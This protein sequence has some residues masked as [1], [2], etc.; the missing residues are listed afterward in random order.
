M[1]SH[2]NAE[3]LLG[4]LNAAR[5]NR[6]FYGKRMDVQHFQME[7]DYGKLKQW[8]LN[9]LT[10][11]MGVLCGLQV[12]VE[13][14]RL[15]VEPGVAIDA[16]GREIVVPARASIAPVLQD[17]GCCGDAAAGETPDGIYT[18]WLCYHECLTDRQAVMASTCGT[19][20]E[21]APSTIVET[22]CLKFEAGAPP[23]QTDPDWC[24]DLWP[25]R[26]EQGE[27]RPPVRGEIGAGGGQG[28]AGGV[29]PRDPE[30][31]DDDV[32][33]MLEARRSRRHILCRLFEETCAPQSG[34]PCVPLA[35]VMLRGGRIL[36]DSCIV[37]PHIYSN[38][39]LLDLILCLAEKIEDCCGKKP[40]KTLLQVRSVDFLNRTPGAA[41]V[42]VGSMAS[43]LEI[44]EVDING[45]PNAIRIRFSKPLAT[46]Q[47]APTT[48]ANGDP[49]YQ[50][51]NVQ[52]LAAD[53]L[54][55]LPFVPGQLTLEAPDTIRFDLDP[56]SPY[57]RSGGGW[58]K[59]RYRLFL[60]GDESLPNQRQALADTDGVALDG[61]AKAPAGGV[62]S[63]NDSAGGD[64]SAEFVIGGKRPSALLHVA[65]VEFYDYDD[66]GAER[67]LGAIKSPLKRTPLK[68]GFR[69]LRIKFDQ[70][71]AAEGPH[72]PSTPAPEEADY[73]RHNVQLLV[74]GDGA[75]QLAM[76][77]LPGELTVEA[78]D[79]LRF[80]VIG[81]NRLVDDNGRWYP[82]QVSL[83]LFLRGTPVPDKQWYELTHADGASL[84]GEPRTPSGGVMSGDDNAG[85]DF[86]AEILVANAA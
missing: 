16:L 75:S 46:D 37:R 53:Q 72:A 64:F 67:K 57:R 60:R 15:Y 34:N 31:L 10:L 1:H 42:L 80:Q 32:A 65:S 62:I 24:A 23:L 40:A 18:L 6:Y 66:A 52:I 21:C 51:H 43:P 26:P 81:G 70:P 22:Y 5:R 39:Q 79:T 3:A 2:D 76:E 4:V 11:G 54:D 35:L 45:Q 27:V 14:G 48:H 28:S 41:E 78:P 71:F 38:R 58:Q 49:D 13:E 50:L 74:T 61:E 30:D 17:G 68:G 84:D 69:Y 86:S 29:K 59:G 36:S 55:G 83:R 9:R 12:S 73:Q 25:K 20:D 77:Y 63:G 82:Q 19:R 85:G 8:M 56:E 33:E 7:Q 44:T 47:H